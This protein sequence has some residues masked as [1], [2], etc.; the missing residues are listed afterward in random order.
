[1][2]VCRDCAYFC[3]T[4]NLVLN[5]YACQKFNRYVKP[6]DSCEAFIAKPS[7][8]RSCF[9]TSACVDYLGKADDCEEL[10]TLRHFRDNYMRSTD[11]GKTLVDEYY[12]IAP[13]IVENINKSEYKDLCYQYIYSVVKYCVALI[14]QEKNEEA[15]AEYQT[16]VVTLKPHF[17]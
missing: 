10:T 5:K 6:T 13:A 12:K 7:G 15:L 16:M 17:A 3:T 14:K 8:G 1:M 2:G 4:N 11:A 9:L